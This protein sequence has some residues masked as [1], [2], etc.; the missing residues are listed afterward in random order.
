MFGNELP[1]APTALPSM[2]SS[3][4]DSPP[5]KATPVQRFVISA[6]LSCFLLL[7]SSRSLADGPSDNIPSQ[8][9]AIPPQGIELPATDR[10]KLQQRVDQI[11]QAINLLPEDVRP[12]DAANAGTHRQPSKSTG[13]KAEVQVFA[14][15]IELALEQSTFYSQDEV[16][17]AHRLADLAIARAARV[18]RAS[19]L[20]NDWL[21]TELATLEPKGHPAGS[22]LLVG[23]FRSQIDGSVQPYGLVVP[24]QWD[25]NQGKP[26]RLDV[27]LHGRGEKVL[28]LQFLHQRLH[29]LGEIQPPDTIVLHPFGRYCNAFKFAGEIDVLEAIEHVKQRFPIDDERISIRGFSMG[30]AG[31]WQ[32]AVHYPGTWMAATPGA[33]FCETID[34]LKGFQQETFVPTAYQRS[35]LHWYDCPDW[36]NNLRG[37]PTIAY[38]GELDKQ[39]QAADLMVAAAKQQGFEIPH[40]VG[41]DTAHKLHPESKQQ[42]EASLAETAKQGRQRQPDRVDFTTYTL[43]YPECHWVSIERLNQHWTPARIQAERHDDHSVQV[44]TQNIRAFRLQLEPVNEKTSRQVT[45]DD[46][47]ILCPGDQTQL[48][49][50]HDG[51]AWTL[52]RSGAATGSRE[53]RPGLQ[54]PIDDAFLSSF[55]FVSPQSVASP[56][57]VDRWVDGE[58][59]HAKAQWRRHFRGEVIERPVAELTVQERTNHNLILFGTPDSNPLIAEVLKTLPIAWTKQGIELHGET[60][61]G[62]SHALVAIYPSPFSPDRYVVLNSGFTYREYA[63][64][65]NARQ[66]A[67][68]PDWAIVDV[69]E[70]ATSQLPGMIPTA[71]FFDEQWQLPPKSAPAK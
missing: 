63:Y 47:N 65:N 69:R 38:S 12:Q 4:S 67:M 10:E 24:A 52:A 26:L 43:R 18:S 53:K 31:C 60:F 27:W 29:D 8:V 57:Q 51:Q 34:F 19:E 13:L 58:L 2:R 23:G 30:G 39:K 32:M 70:G 55:I 54:G 35:L 14:R 48:S 3:P 36:V 15:A 41:P 50:K 1:V 11:H 16:Q 33:G 22:R 40:L 71:G 49:F 61:P 5:A 66:I 21:T 9:R 7:P 68:L 59:S 37:L 20:G 64:L 45:V 17:Q 56:E 62:D 42:I 46:Q 44:S 28:E 6:V 25:A